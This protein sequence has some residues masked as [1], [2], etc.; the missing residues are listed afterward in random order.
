MEGYS[1]NELKMI[2]AYFKILSQHL[3]KGLRR[4]L[5]SKPPEYETGI[6]IIRQRCPVPK[7]TRR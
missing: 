6:L 1:V 4:N 7:S 5:N 2:V 3:S